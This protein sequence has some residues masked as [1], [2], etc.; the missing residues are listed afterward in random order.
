MADEQEN[1]AANFNAFIDAIAGPDNDYRIAVVTT[2][3]SSDFERQGLRDDRFVLEPGTGVEAFVQSGVS[4]CSA[5]D[6]PMGCVRGPDPSRRVI[7]STVLSRDDQISAFV[8]NVRVGSCGSGKEEGLGAMLDALGKRDGCNQ[9]FIR[10]EANLVVILV[11]D[12]E[13]FS[14]MPDPA[15]PNREVLVPVA[16]FVEDMKNVKNLAQVR[17]AVIVGADGGEA[18]NCSAA[19][20]AACGGLCRGPG[21][22]PSSNVACNAMTAPAVC[23]AHEGCFG[24]MCTSEP[25]R[26]WESDPTSCL[27]CSYFKAPDCCSALAGRRYVDFALQMEAALNGIDSTFAI[28]GCTGAQPDPMQNT[29]TACLI[30]SICQDSFAATLERIAK[31]LVFNADFTIEPPAL[32]PEGLRVRLKGG[33]WG[34]EGIELE[35]G[36]DYDASPT[37]VTLKGDKIPSNDEEIEIYYVSD[38]IDSTSM[39]RGACGIE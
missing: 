7:D 10:P 11:S 15:D 27:W 12:E 32:N 2:D 26:V 18:S 21:P 9:G 29:R 24:G 33:R 8:Q 3:Q 17:V 14:T 36:V 30:D 20:G 6:I 25:A 31:D 38:K 37:R 1:L 16:Q 5:S 13:D 4:G 39:P 28:T 35:P 34:E 22:A 23:Q 19:V